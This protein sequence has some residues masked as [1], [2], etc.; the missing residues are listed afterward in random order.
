MKILDYNSDAVIKGLFDLTGKTAIITGGGGGLGLAMAKGYANYGANLVL[1]GRTQ[2]TLDKAAAELASTGAQV[3]TVSAD[4]LNP[5]DCQK[6]VQETVA[7]FGAI[8]ILVPAA[9]LARRHPAEEFPK[10]DFD[11]VI[12]T[13]VKGTWYIDQAVGQQLIKQYKD[14]RPGGKIINITSVR[15][16]NG[17]PLGYGAYATSKGAVISMTRQLAFEWAQYD[18]NVNALGPTIVMSALTKPVF[19]N[20]ESAKVF[21]DRILF[22]R[23]MEPGELIGSA[24]YLAAPASDFVTGQ[25]LYVDGGCVAA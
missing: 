15:A 24:V 16:N 8:D 19:D 21:T 11:I 13:N 20:P 25:I 17:H 9:G 6:I 12:D 3:L 18:I 5:D 22:H 23:P 2:A 14:G 7:K 4:T 10:A 1:T